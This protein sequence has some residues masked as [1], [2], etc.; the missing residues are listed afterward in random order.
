M[1]LS[2]KNLTVKY[3]KADALKGVSIELNE[4]D[5][6]AVVGAN[7]AGKTTLL[8]SISGLKQ[9]ASGEV[10][11]DGRLISKASP[12][13]IVGMGIYHIPQG[14]RLFPYMT[15]MEN[16]MMGAYLR[17]DK[18]AIKRDLADV[19]SHFPVL[20]RNKGRR[21]ET[22]SGGEQQMLAIGRGLMS[23][24]RVLMM[25]E[26]SHGLSPIMVDEISRVIADINK[27][28][29]SIVLVEQNVT[30]AL[31]IASKGYVI[32]TGRVVLEGRPGE[33]LSDDEV[34]KAYLGA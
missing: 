26:P 8:R 13:R 34:R 19:Y 21:A 30:M 3:G 24:P 4:G 20:E 1:L 2:V 11:F 6:I 33:I 14:R 12:P 31:K 27:R 18:D 23:R 17:R 32:S 10:W 29:V 22:F 15:V 5:I 25:D 28:G 16:L 7:G 9:P